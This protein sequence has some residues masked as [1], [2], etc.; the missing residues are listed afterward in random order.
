MFI[1]K[2]VVKNPSLQDYGGTN[3]TVTQAFGKISLKTSIVL[4]FSS[5]GSITSKNSI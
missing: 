2:T 1:A 4:D 5:I 3:I